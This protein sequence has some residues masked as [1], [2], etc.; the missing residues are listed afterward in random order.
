MGDLKQRA[1]DPAL[2]EMNDNPIA[3]GFSVECEPVTRGRKNRKRPFHGDEN[4]SAAGN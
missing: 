2:K 4:R 1:I 3:A